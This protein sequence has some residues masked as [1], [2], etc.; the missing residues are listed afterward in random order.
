MEAAVGMDALPAGAVFKIFGTV[1]SMGRMETD[2]KSGEHT[3]TIEISGA[4]GLSWYDARD[5][6]SWLMGMYG[7][8][9]HEGKSV[10]IDLG[11]I[12]WMDSG[13]YAEL[14][15]IAAANSRLGY[16]NLLLK[17]VHGSVERL[18]DMDPHNYLVF[19]FV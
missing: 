1:L 18:L 19:D 15:G 17:G 3:N 7:D 14:L 8:G 5:L 16:G 10:C 13:A 6:G 2:M 4:D 11:N 12:E 9:T